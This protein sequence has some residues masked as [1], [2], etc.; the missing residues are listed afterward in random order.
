[1]RLDIS[2]DSSSTKLNGIPRTVT[3]EVIEGCWTEFSR[4]LKTIETINCYQTVKSIDIYYLS[5]GMILMYLPLVLDKVFVVT[6]TSIV[7]LMLL[8]SSRRFSGEDLS[9]KFCV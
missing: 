6:E 7:D 5:Y 1:M 9:F 3:G 2:A 4:K 8:V